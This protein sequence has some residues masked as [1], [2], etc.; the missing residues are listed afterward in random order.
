[1]SVMCWSK[2]VAMVIAGAATA[3]VAAGVPTVV[4][5]QG[6]A[7]EARAFN[8]PAQPLADGLT[9]FGRQSGLQVSVDAA[10]VRGRSTAGVSGTLTPVEALNTLL[11]GTGIVYRF[12]N[13]TT[14]TLE[15]PAGAGGAAAPGAVQLDPVRVQSNT[16]PPQAEIGN[17]ATGID[18]RQVADLGL[19][20]QGRAAG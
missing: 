12:V 19:R 6:A 8:I 15:R 1:M 11:A 18:G 7:A 2:V 4:L 17:L 3:A 16:P 5:A 13:A 14:V 20:R 9:A 10:L